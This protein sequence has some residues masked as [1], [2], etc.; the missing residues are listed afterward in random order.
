MVTNLSRENP[1]F[2][3]ALT[4]VDAKLCFAESTGTSKLKDGRN[5]KPSSHVLYTSSGVFGSKISN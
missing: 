4:N 3:K 5:T 1:A 2:T